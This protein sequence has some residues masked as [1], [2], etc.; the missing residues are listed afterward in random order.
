MTQ[1]TRQIVFLL[2]VLVQLDGF[3][4]KSDNSN[5]I[6]NDIT[7][8]SA[9]QDTVTDKN[10]D[11]TERRYKMAIEEFKSINDT[12]QTITGLVNLSTY[13]AHVADFHKAYEGYWKALL[14]ADE[15]NDELAKA[16]VYEGLGWLY[17]LFSRLEKSKEYFNQLLKVRKRYVKNGTLKQ[18]TL[19][20]G[21][22]ALAV[23]HRKNQE[24]NMARR[25]LDSCQQVQS[26]FDKEVSTAFMEA[27]LAYVSFN[28]GGY[29]KSLN[30]LLKNR[31]YFEQ[32]HPAYVILLDSFLGD[33]YKEMGE[34]NSSEQFYL[35]AMRIG[36]LY[37]SHQDHIPTIYENLS[38][39]YYRMNRPEAAYKYLNMS[40]TLEERQFGTRSVHNQK[41]MEITD[42]YRL[43]KE[44][45][46]D[47]I[48]KQRLEQLEQ[49]AEIAQ[50]KATILYVTI[51]SLILVIFLVYRFLRAKYKAQKRAIQ[52][53][54][55]LELQKAEEILEV[56]NKELTKSTLQ[57]IERDELLSELKSKL[58]E[59]H[60][61]TNEGSINKIV[62]QIDFN[63]NLNWEEFNARFIAVNT[64]FYDELKKRFPKL[65]QS[66]KKICALIKLN[67]SSKDMAKLLG[68]SVESVHTTRYRLRKKLKLTRQDNLED[69]IGTL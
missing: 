6:V 32:N 38:E 8:T 30:L 3:S 43:E 61:K 2:L 1:Y 55:E 64:S 66:D 60:K 69:F 58:N 25:Y 18:E 28:E 15:S 48:Q 7:K 19:L 14:L 24:N 40:K 13:Y 20:S 5:G 42:T 53:Q 50:L 45:K 67:F 22:Y 59:Q 41:M 11:S 49:R 34:H 27:E 9:Q 44:K 17:S 68:I 23:L 65:T 36:E 26:V 10:H 51:V 46:D 54:K 57:L 56:K 52:Q 35:N 63:K 47:F 37:R 29:E 21:Y 33:I 16:K 12:V 62:S 39:L 31:P 4:Q